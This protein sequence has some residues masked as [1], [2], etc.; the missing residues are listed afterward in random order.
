MNIRTKN[1]K[2]NESEQFQQ[3]TPL[4]QKAQQIDTKAEEIVMKNKS[5]QFKF[6]CGVIMGRIDVEIPNKFGLN[7]HYINTDS[8][9]N[10]IG[11]VSKFIGVSGNSLTE[12]DQENLRKQYDRMQFGK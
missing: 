5:K 3:Q 6:D 11:S 4:Q 1:K 9:D 7:W 12:T 8:L 10:F 2:L